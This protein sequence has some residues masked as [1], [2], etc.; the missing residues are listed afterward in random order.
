MDNVLVY[1]SAKAQKHKTTMRS[2]GNG[3]R[4]ELTQHRNLGLIESSD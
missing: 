4:V 1:A 2:G 3:F